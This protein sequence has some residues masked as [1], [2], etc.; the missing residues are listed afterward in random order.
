MG[1][2]IQRALPDTKVVKALNTLN[3]YLMT[4]PSG[5]QGEQTIFIC[6]NDAEAKAQVT[7]W[8]NE[9]LGWPE[10]MILDVGDITAARGTE[11]LMALWIRLY[12]NFKTGMFNWHIVK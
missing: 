11:M 8:L 9:W 5:L 12:G 7:K 1:E 3:V 10:R 6:G 2:Q 4:N